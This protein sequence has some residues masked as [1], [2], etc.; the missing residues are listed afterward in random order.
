MI[1]RKVKENNNDLTS[2]MNMTKEELIDIIMKNKSAV[3]SAFLEKDNLKKEV[4]SLSR[5]KNKLSK[6][7]DKLQQ[8]NS[9][10]KTELRIK[11]AIIKRMGLEI[12]CDKSDN[13]NQHGDSRKSV[14]F[15][16]EKKQ[17]SGKPGRKTGSKNY[18]SSDLEKLS[19]GNEVI[20]NDVLPEYMKTHPNAKLVKIGEN[21]TYLIEHQ[22]AVFKVHKVITPKYR[23]EDGKIIQATSQSIVNHCLLSSSSLA[24][25]IAA[26]YSL[27]I[28]VNRMKYLLESQGIDFS[29]GTI[30]G[31]LMKSAI[32][33]KPIWKA[34]IDHLSDGTYNKI[35]IDETTIRVMEECKDSRKQCYMYVYGADNQEEHLRL[36]DYTRT[37]ESA[38]VKGY[39]GKYQGTIVTDGYKGYDSLESENIKI[40]CCTV[41]L[42]RYFTN[43]TKVMREE[44][45]E[46]SEAMKVVE[47]LDKL[48]EMEADFKQRNLTA[49]EILKERSSDEYM[50]SVNAVQEKLDFL[51]TQDLGSDL[52][53]AVDYYQHRK[54]KFWTYLNDGN[55]EMHNNEAERIA[56]S[57]ASLR[58]TFLFCKSNESAE[59]C[60]ILMSLV[61]S[62]EACNIY[63]DS[64][65]EWALNGI[66][67]N[68][69]GKDLFPWAEECKSFKIKD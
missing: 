25:F 32:L 24:Y 30:Y 19:K 62:A 39:L 2:Y 53:K 56:K 40:Q 6:K 45:R 46:N 66:K 63:P 43:I 10:L 38:N 69:K 47:L 29:I 27:G 12:Y 33:L 5:E 16:P 50:K 3:S 67:E 65:L 35:N 31:W 11:N 51:N 55:V 1:N 20:N 7:N 64:Y 26:K 54:N 23:T 52:K 44:D 61:K 42:R 57:F 60:A 41:H 58:K 21:E 22:K 37:R 15:S 59:N 14:R 49:D 17:T 8:E 68:K 48:F 36:M 18:G 34:M 4:E 28:P 9:K 13:A